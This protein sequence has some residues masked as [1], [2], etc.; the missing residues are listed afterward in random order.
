MGSTHSRIEETTWYMEEDPDVVHEWEAEDNGNVKKNDSREAY[1]T[2]RCWVAYWV[3]RRNIRHLSSRKRKSEEH[4]CAN[5]FTQGSDEIY[6][7]LVGITSNDLLYFKNAH[8]SW[9]Y[10]LSIE[11]TVAAWFLSFQVS[12]RV[13]SLNLKCSLM[14]GDIPL[15][16]IPC[17]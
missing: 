12:S 9:Y 10:Y 14:A 13:R 1:S 15:R 5:I 3:S 7:T 2:L 4:G 16:Y 6:C 8:G 11:F 17:R